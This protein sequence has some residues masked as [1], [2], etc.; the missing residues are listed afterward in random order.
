M[1]FHSLQMMLQFYFVLTTCFKI[2]A[3]PFND[4]PKHLETWTA[5]KVEDARLTTAASS[6]LQP[7]SND[8]KVKHVAIGR[9]SQNY[10]CLTND[11]SAAPSSVGALA[12]LFDASCIAIKD[13]AKLARLPKDALQSKLPADDSKTLT[14]SKIEVSGHHYFPDPQTPVFELSTAA[15]NLGSV[16]PKKADSK[17]AP[18]NAIAGKNN[19]GFG[20]VPWLKLIANGDI[21]EVYRV[22]TAGGNPPKTCKDMP[23]TFVVQYAAE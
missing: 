2:L 7:P 23:E 16:S 10:T 3:F 18:P 20:A 13:P 4:S 11:P 21:K 15:S 22:N 12:T 1:V 6:P 19:K 8:V 17:P 5:C 14:S 9:G